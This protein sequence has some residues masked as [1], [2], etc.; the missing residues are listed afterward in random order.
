MTTHEALAL[1]ALTLSP[2]M[3]MTA[4]HPIPSHS[5]SPVPG[6][7]EG[8]AS[9]PSVSQPVEQSLQAQGLQSL[10]SPALKQA[11]MVSRLQQLMAWQE[12]QKA[13]LFR[14]QQEEIMRLHR[15]HHVSEVVEEKD[16]ELLPY[17]H[18]PYH[19]YGGL[20]GGGV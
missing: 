15:L 2:S 16:G 13:T 4:F 17:W 5:R 20:G 1:S 11:E 7:G 19:L 6:G 8:Q 9:S 14:Q 12:R 18:V 10:L 3:S